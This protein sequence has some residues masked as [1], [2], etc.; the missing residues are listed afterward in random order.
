MG[1]IYTNGIPMELLFPME[2]LWIFH[3][4]YLKT[5]GIPNRRC[6]L[7]YSNLD[8]FARRSTDDDDDWSL[9]RWKIPRAMLDFVWEDQP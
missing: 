1:N 9:L 5:N 3:G 8:R 2:F 4:K 7:S 6:K